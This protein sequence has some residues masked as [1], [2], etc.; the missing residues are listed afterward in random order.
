VSTPARDASCSVL[1][2]RL[3]AVGD[4]CDD[5]ALGEVVGLR[6]LDTLGALVA[7]HGAEATR[8][9]PEAS[10]LLGN[11]RR[12]CATV[13]C[14]EIDDFE[15]L[16][17]TTPGSVAVPVALL[18]GIA[19]DA[20]AQRIRAGIVAGYEAMIAV[21]EATDGPHRLA[22]G[23]WPSHLAAP[24]AAAATTAA[25]LGLDDERTTHALAIAATRS[26]GSAGQIASEP[27]SR[28]YTYGL[29][30]DDGVSAALA[31]EAGMLGDPD[32]L[33]GPLSANTG[34]DLD[35]A[36]FPS[37][38]ARITSV[39]VK[40]F[41]TARQAQAAVEAATLAYADLGGAPIDAIEVAVPAAYRA[42]VDQPEPA[43]RL[44]SL[45]SAQRQIALALTGGAGLYDV[46]REDLRLSPEADRI[47]RATRVVADDE[48]TEMY[49][50]VLPA[51]VRIRAVG[52]GEAERLVR[53]PLGARERPL[54]WA[55][56]YEKHTR[57]GAWGERLA[58]AMR[59]S[60]ELG[61]GA[62]PAPARELL[63]LTQHL[64][65]E[66]VT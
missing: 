59:L 2:A 34:I 25:V 50:D 47:M 24:I 19:R 18:V 39:D 53:D 13:R 38:V 21:G 63:D 44:K 48:L 15:R 29:A 56:L 60:R 51:R 40:P 20:P 27:T 14:S 35:V 6:V 8:V 55:A 33:A 45:T 62:G 7:A 32:A 9:I 10:G 28:W 36:R 54:G 57:I 41:C 46:A 65:Q 3:R 23:V 42:M 49:P 31:A 52:G 58:K 37:G 1:A 12:L 64:P 4:A 11:V 5:E 16:S 66:A 17:C 22:Q 43:S 30:A 26:V 61:A